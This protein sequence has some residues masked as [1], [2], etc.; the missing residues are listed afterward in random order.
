MVPTR[1]HVR[2]LLA[3]VDIEAQR[4]G[5]CPQGWYHNTIH[6]TAGT[7]DDYEVVLVET[8]VRSTILLETYRPLLWSLASSCVSSL[9]VGDLRLRFRLRH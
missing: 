4:W 8:V 5:G 1:R 3:V 9:A 7:D 2:L 6:A